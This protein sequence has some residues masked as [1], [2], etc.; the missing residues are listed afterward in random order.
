[1]VNGYQVLLRDLLGAFLSQCD[2]KARKV[3]HVDSRQRVLAVTD[4]WQSSEIRMQR[5]PGASE[6]LIEAI[7]CLAI[8]INQTTAYHMH[9]KLLVELIR[10][11]RQIL[12]VL[13]LLKLRKR[14]ASREV[15]VR[16]CCR[17]AL[18]VGPS[19]HWRD[20]NQHLVL[21][22][23][24]RTRL[25][26]NLQDLFGFFHVCSTLQVNDEDVALKYILGECLWLLAYVQNSERVRGHW[27]R[28]FILLDNCCNK[29]M[30]TSSSFDCNIVVTHL[31]EKTM[32]Q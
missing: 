26:E 14:N 2:Y 15:S 18:A 9:A 21:V 31:F 24:F 13:C 16:I 10:G 4:H 6:E 8:S 25:S 20:H 30:S 7:V 28:G 12:D 22:V 19:E 29:L 11:H 27:R 17:A 23:L 32:A 5:N 1:L 3:A